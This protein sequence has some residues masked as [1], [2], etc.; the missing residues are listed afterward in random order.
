MQTSTTKHMCIVQTVSFDKLIFYIKKKLEINYIAYDMRFIIYYSC[1]FSFIIII[2]TMWINVD[3]QQIISNKYIM[4]L[5]KGFDEFYK[6]Y[7][8]RI[9]NSIKS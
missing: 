2:T 6:L 4:E 5:K 1:V 8:V 9:G 7:R 3:K